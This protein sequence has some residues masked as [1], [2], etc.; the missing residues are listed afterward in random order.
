MRDD[1]EHEQEP[2]GRG[3]DNEEIGGGNLVEMVL[4]E[5]APSLD[6]GFSRRI[7]YFATEAWPTSIP[8]FSNSP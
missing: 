3:R 8:S 5:R 4:E 7:M 1:D 2:A 6:G